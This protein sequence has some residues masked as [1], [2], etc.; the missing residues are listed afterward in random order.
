MSAVCVVHFICVVKEVTRYCLIKSM[1]CVGIVLHKG[2]HFLLKYVND[3]FI[4]LVSGVTI[5]N[6]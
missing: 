3:S 5:S 1:Q 6:V 2:R 4:V